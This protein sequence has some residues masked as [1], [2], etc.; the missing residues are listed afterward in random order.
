M[1]EVLRTRPI[2]DSVSREVIAPSIALGPW[3]IPRGHIVTVNIGLVQENE[4]VLTTRQRSTPT[5]SSTGTLDFIPGCRS[6]GGLGVVPERRSPIW[7]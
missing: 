7:K 6:A 4:A 5:D 2:I 3:V 1:Y